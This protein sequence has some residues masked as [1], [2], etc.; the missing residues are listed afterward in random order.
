MSGRL[1]EDTRQA[2]ERLLGMINFDDGVMVEKQLALLDEALEESED[3]PDGA[4]LLRIVQE[5]IDWEA[6]FEVEQT[7]SATFI[8]SLNQLTARLD[9]VLDWGV[10]DPEDEDFLGGTSVAELMEQAHEQ[11]RPMGITLWHWESGAGVYAGWLARSEDE[12]EILAVA[13]QLEVEVRTG[14]QPF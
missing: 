8:D 10:D 5:A 6:G 11:L 12:E 13:E 1:D 3:I 2:V 9:I 7:D 4:E 14:D